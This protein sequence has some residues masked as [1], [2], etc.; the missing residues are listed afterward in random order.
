MRPCSAQVPVAVVALPRPAQPDRARCCDWRSAP[1]PAVGHPAPTARR[2]ARPVPAPCCG[3]G[4]R[5]MVAGLRWPDRSGADR[6]GLSLRAMIALSLWIALAHRYAAPLIRHAGAAR[7]CFAPVRRCRSRPHARWRSRRSQLAHRPAHRPADQ[8]RV[9]RCV[10]RRTHA[11]VRVIRW[12]TP[13]PR[14]TAARTSGR[15]RTAVAPMPAPH[16]RFLPVPGSRA[17]WW[18]PARGLRRTAPGHPL[19]SPGWLADHAADAATARGLC[20]ATTGG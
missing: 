7:Q 4:H 8:A 15:L 9:P 3:W 12:S 17:G 20:P 18:R 10:R 2:S 14:N 13:A 19:R 1:A 5:S 16:R 6:P 11:A